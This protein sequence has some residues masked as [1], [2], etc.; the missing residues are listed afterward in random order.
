[1][2]E[3][4]A[5]LVIP[6]VAL[7]RSRGR[8]SS[9][10]KRGSFYCVRRLDVLALF[11]FAA[12]TNFLFGQGQ[13]RA[14]GIA[15]IVSFPLAHFFRLSRVLNHAVPV[16]F[17]I[18]L[19][20][21]WVFW[22]GLTG[23]LVAVDLELFW[24]GY[25]VL[26]QMFAMVWTVYLILCT[27]DDV[28]IVFVAIVVGGLIQV[29]QVFIFNDNTLSETELTKRIV[30]STSNPNDLGF[31]M[32][33]FVL[34]AMMF[35]TQYPK[36]QKILNGFILAVIPVA[37]YI[38]LFSGSRKSTIAL[39]FLVFGWTTFA[40]RAKIGAKRILVSLLI[41]ITLIAGFLELTPVFFED[42][43]AGYRFKI[44]LD[45][46]RGNLWQ[47]IEHYSRY[48]MYVDGLRIFLEH[49]I[50][51]VGLNN[52][53]KHY[54]GGATYS[55]SNY[56]EPLATTGLIGFV[57]YHAFYVLLLFRIH[58]LLNVIK[59]NTAQ[60]RLKV[61][62]LGIIAM[63]I[64]G[65]GAPQ[66]TM[67]TVFLLLTAFSVFTIRLARRCSLHNRMNRRNSRL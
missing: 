59:T 20:S 27:M 50:F 51:G 6:S 39:G 2:P 49:P 29:I 36:R 13:Q 55:H 46:G 22:S 28:D 62:L 26:L 60:Y 63:M 53:Q 33:W 30:G 41:G 21:A 17:E 44:F 14:L 15:M 65:I 66:Y 64:I 43:V 56:I 9:P 42:T 38:L 67:P 40:L 54:I 25:E 16:P 45:N 37:T 58:R 12:G 7:W 32:I 3:K 10:N 8:Q 57:F 24:T 18:K 47:N 11:T 35:W 1:M 19:Y 4:Q 34:C 52:F 61:M 31:L 23:P 48:E 5:T